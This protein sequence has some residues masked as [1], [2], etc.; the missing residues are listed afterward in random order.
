MLFRISIKLTMKYEV[1]LQLPVKHIQLPV[2][3]TGWGGTLIQ[4]IYCNVSFI[5]KDGHN[6]LVHGDYMH[7]KKSN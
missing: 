4:G 6:Q 2:I 5:W 1:Y 3:L 7:K